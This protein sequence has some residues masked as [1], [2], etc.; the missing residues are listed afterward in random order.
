MSVNPYQ[1]PDTPSQAPPAKPGRFK[2]TLVELLVVLFVIAII[3]GLLLP[4]RRGSSGGGRR[5]YCSN[6]LKQIGL[7]LHN[8]HDKYGALPPAYTVDEDGK[9]LHSWRTLI[10]PFMEQQA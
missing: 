5:M 3:V 7:A 10:L 4:A 8:Y 1:S 2:F 6:N 9:P